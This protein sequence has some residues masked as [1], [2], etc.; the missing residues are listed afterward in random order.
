M[1]SSGINAGLGKYVPLV[2]DGR[3]SGASHGIMVGHVTPEASDG[4]PIAL[5]R[6]GDMITVAP[7]DRLLSVD[8]SADELAARKAAWVPPPPKQGCRGVLSRYAKC[9]ASAHYGATTS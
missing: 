5:L 4:G 7:R 6:D 8:L 3:F 2:T 9:V 1:G